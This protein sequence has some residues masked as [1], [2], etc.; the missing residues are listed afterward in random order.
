M[1][2]RGQNIVSKLYLWIKVIGIIFIKTKFFSRPFPTTL[3]VWINK[4]RKKKKTSEQIDLPG[5]SNRRNE[6]RTPCTTAVGSARGN[7]H[8]TR[9]TG[10][11]ETTTARRTR[12]LI[13]NYPSRW[14][15]DQ[16]TAA[17]AT[18]LPPRRG[19]RR[20]APPDP[21]TP[22]TSGS[23][24]VFTRALRFTFTFFFF[25]CC[26]LIIVVIYADFE[27]IFFGK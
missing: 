18:L 20:R 4:I 6:R 22:A 12:A 10:S 14:P 26:Q 13:E 27:V 7:A 19:R 25:F 11:G 2:C 16:R 8:D 23:S 17:S 24:G 1:P 9:H 5:H 21:E 3:F 15:R